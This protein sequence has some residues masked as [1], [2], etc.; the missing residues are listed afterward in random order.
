MPQLL[1]TIEQQFRLFPQITRGENTFHKFR[2]VL[3]FPRETL[4]RYRQSRAATSLFVADEFDQAYGTETTVRVHATDLEIANPNWIHASPYFPTPSR[5]LPEV[6]AGLDLQFDKLTFVDLGSGKGRMVLMA[7]QFPFRRIIG[8]EF[9][10]QLHDVATTNL[11]RYSG[12]KRCSRI[13]LLCQDFTEFAFPTEPLFVFLYNPA[14]AHL[15]SVLAQ[16]LM[17]SL[18]RSPREVWILYVTP[19]EVFAGEKQLE[20]VKAGE[21]AGH[22]WVL[23]RGV[24]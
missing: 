6:L 14:N 11:F 10:E 4:R 16:N 3:L 8:V 5:L 17:R 15:S 9:S 2:S 12:P 13:Q 22:P 18:S 7:A 24:R 19:Y 20:T 21:F 1:R 23:Y